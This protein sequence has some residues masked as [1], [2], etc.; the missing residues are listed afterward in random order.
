MW[1]NIFL[2]INC[3]ILKWRKSNIKITT[4]K[5]HTKL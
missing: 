5:I 2:F 4:V 1:G 3:S